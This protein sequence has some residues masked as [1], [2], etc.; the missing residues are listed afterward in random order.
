[1]AWSI[2]LSLLFLAL[3]ASFSKPTINRTN[4]EKTS[5]C[6]EDYL[7]E[8]KDFM[9]F[10]FE[11]AGNNTQY[12]FHDGFLGPKFFFSTAEKPVNTIECYGFDLFTDA[13]KDRRGAP[14]ACTCIEVHP[15]KVY[16]FIYNMTADRKFSN[17]SFWMAWA[18]FPL[19][20]S[21]RFQIPEIRVRF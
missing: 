21:E 13:C 14:N 1:M 15:S 7:V 2:V 8:G 18:G 3:R 19:I 10:V 11:A 6:S 20:S 5:S 9:L 16:R 17:Q 4:L 12:P